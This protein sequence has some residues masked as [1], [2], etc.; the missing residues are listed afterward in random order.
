MTETH[1]LSTSF[2]SKPNSLTASLVLGRVQRLIA[3]ARPNEHRAMLHVE[4]H[5]GLRNVSTE[6]HSHAIQVCNTIMQYH[7]LIAQ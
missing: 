6:Q 3:A 2:N 1:S 5:D 7:E 4:V